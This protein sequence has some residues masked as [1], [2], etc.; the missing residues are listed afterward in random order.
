MNSS[1]MLGLI[2]LRRVSRGRACFLL[3]GVVGVHF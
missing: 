3:V 2:K 1:F